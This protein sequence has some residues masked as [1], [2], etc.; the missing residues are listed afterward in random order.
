MASVEP[1]LS[2]ANQ[3]PILTLKEVADYLR[4][5]PSTVY[6]LVNASEIPSFKIGSN[7]RFSLDSIDRWRQGKEEVANK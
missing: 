4:V 3:A 6:R 5:H 1:N 2:S 7:W